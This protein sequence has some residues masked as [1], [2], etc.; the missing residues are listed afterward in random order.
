[1]KLRISK[2]LIKN[3]FKIAIVCFAVVDLVIIAG[4][5]YILAQQSKTGNIPTADEFVDVMSCLRA[6]DTSKQACLDSFMGNY[7]ESRGLSIKQALGDLENARSQN[8]DIENE[9]HVISHAIGRY[10]YVKEGNV[11][12]AFESCDQSCH[13]G[14]YHG[15]MERLFYGEDET[16]DTTKHLTLADLETK[17]PNICD[18][19]NFSNPTNAL[20][21]QC[22]HGVGHAILYSLDYNLGDSL[23]ACDLME[24]GYERSSC[25]GGV[26]MENVTAFER[27]KRDVDRTDPHYPCNKLADQYKYDCYQMQT[28]LMFEF[29]LNYEQMAAE[30]KLAGD[31]QRPCFVSLGRDLSNYVRMN[32]ASLV[33]DVCE[34]VSEGNTA[35]CVNGA[36]YALIDNTW[37]G[38][39]ALPFCDALLKDGNK[40]NCFMAA[41]SYLRSTY[42][43]ND[44]EVN[45]EC[46]K[47]APSARYCKI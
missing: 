20:I 27:S 33:V 22:L 41:R 3:K 29:G 38:E 14:C 44:V 42:A 36:I 15:V 5:V 18:R 4:V 37:S 25:Y 28:S 6:D 24:T 47:Y 32:N 12:D 13:S 1:M 11:G 23:A 26:I 30:C 39:F 40:E 34:R 17:V 16:A 43:K 10:A 31:Y 2:K 9:C 46:D 45:A 8:A 21:F 35:N 7:I 19:S